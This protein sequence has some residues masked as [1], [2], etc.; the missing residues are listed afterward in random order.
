[1]I[2]CIIL[3]AGQSERFGSPKALAPIK[4]S[5]AL[6]RIQN[7]LLKSTCHETLVVLGAHAHQIFPSI[8]I[9]RGVRLVYNKDHNF[10]QMSSIQE[11]IRRADPNSKGFLFLP[12]DC[13][14]INSN[15]IDKVILKFKETD[16]DIL[17][18]TYK[19][20]KGHPP[21][22][23][24][25]MASKILALP[26]SLGLNSLF[27]EHPPQTIEIDDEGIIQSFNTP[28]ELNKLTSRL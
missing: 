10:G 16:P 3:A 17:I 18:P 13:P 11:G 28:E 14:F 1:M 8:F 22:F 23:N 9:H 27:T 24:Q 25:R 26:M 2:T 19:N 5:N 15:T 6:E 20:K 12:V 7:T 21:I 4:E